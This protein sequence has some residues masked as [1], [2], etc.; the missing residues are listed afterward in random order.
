ME[1][2]NQSN[3]RF[4]LFII[5]SF[6]IFLGWSYAYEKVYPTQKGKSPTPAAS[7]ASSTVATTKQATPFPATQTTSSLV[8][9]SAPAPQ[10][11]LREVRVRTELWRAVLSNQGAVITD[12][13]SVRTHI[14]K[15]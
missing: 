14:A 10:T 2:E 13:C 5:L 11:E 4:V 12:Q 9:P 15:G 3:P 8:Q 1:N 6:L 7:P